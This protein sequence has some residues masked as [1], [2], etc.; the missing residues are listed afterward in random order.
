MLKGIYVHE[1]S[2]YVSKLDTDAENPTK[3]HVG[4]L[5]PFLEAYINDTAT[6]AVK[7]EQGAGEEELEVKLNLSLR[8]LLT[9]KFCVRKIE[10][11]WD[12]KKKEA[13]T[14]EATAVKI[15]SR[16]YTA[17][18]D[19]VIAALPGGTAILMELSLEARRLNTLSEEEAK[20]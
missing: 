1:I 6:T 4:V 16:E 5:D 20:N 12:P 8:N 19:D 7:K 14:I 2:V 18:P 10:N 3:F 9:V 11:F 15:G 13:V 17:L